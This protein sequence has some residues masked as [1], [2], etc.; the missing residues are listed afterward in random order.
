MLSSVQAKL[1]RV[2][3]APEVRQGC[4]EDWDELWQA[5]LK[6]Q[7]ALPVAKN[8]GV[9]ASA[10]WLLEQ[11]LAHEAKLHW[12]RKIAGRL[13]AAS[14]TAVHLKG[15]VF[16]ERFYDPPC[17][18]PSLDLDVALHQSQIQQAVGALESLGYAAEPLHFVAMD[19]HV[20]LLHDHAPEVELHY[21]LLS[22]FG[23]SREVEGL[24]ARSR[25]VEVPKLGSVRV[26]EAHDEFVFLCAHAAKH[27]FRPLR[28]MYDLARILETT[29]LDW[30][31][32]W[33]RASRLHVRRLLA[34]TVVVLRRDWDFP[35]SGIPIPAADLERAARILPGFTQPRPPAR[36]K[37]DLVRKYA[38]DMGAC[39]DLGARLRSCWRLG[40][41]FAKR[42]MKE[43]FA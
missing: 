37:P 21:R 6:E 14:V 40:A 4:P 7:V 33:Q 25:A 34:L 32:V 38:A 41:S 36:T 8:L 12:L 5:A 2:L 15:P 20:V 24:V 35:L 22:E 19:Q 18:R 43:A 26:P 28:F 1:V 39:D 16:A 27:R 23:A 31:L 10:Q 30:N 17:G 3:R 42:V 9:A 11:E 29:P 13:E